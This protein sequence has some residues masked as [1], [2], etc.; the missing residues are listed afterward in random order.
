MTRVGTTALIGG[1][2]AAVS[3]ICAIALAQG[4]PP[5]RIGASLS[6]TGSYAVIGQVQ[7]RAYQLCVKHMNDKGGVLARQLAL[8]VEDDR[9]DAATAI[10]IY[11]KLIAQDKVDAI[12]GPYT[13]ALTE[14]VADVAEKHR[15]PLVAP[16]AGVPPSTRRGGGSSS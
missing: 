15:M 16:T 5:I 8:V 1:I 9:S 11:Q 2:V 12:L 10:R 13:S 3:L 7:L 14:A 4:P 6:Q